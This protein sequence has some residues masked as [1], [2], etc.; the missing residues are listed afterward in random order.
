[1]KNSNAPGGEVDGRGEELCYATMMDCMSE[2][3]AVCICDQRVDELVC[4]WDLEKQVSKL[5]RTLILMVGSRKNWND[6]G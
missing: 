2:R 4:W 3:R 1:M 5:R 6:A